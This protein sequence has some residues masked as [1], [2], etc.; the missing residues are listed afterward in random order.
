MIVTI[1]GKE[2]AQDVE[3]DELGGGRYHV[4]VSELPPGDYTYTG[5]AS[6]QG[7]QVG[8]SKGEFSI[9]RYSLEFGDMRM[10]QALLSRIAYESGGKFYLAEEAHRL[11]EDMDLASTALETKREITLWN[12]PWLFGLL[13]LLLAVEWTIRK[14]RGMV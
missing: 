9:G 3:M 10:N 11:L 2:T 4:E 14:R 6:V 8:E 13:V 5:R 1:N 7:R 12:S